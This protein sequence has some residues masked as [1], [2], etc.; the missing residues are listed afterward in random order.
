L[1]TPALPGRPND[2]TTLMSMR[3]IAELAGVKRPVVTTWRR[4]HPDFPGPCGGDELGPLF[5]PRQVADWLVRTGRITSEQA[6]VDLSFYTLTGLGAGLS[7]KDLIAGVTALICLR[8]LDDGEPLAGGTDDIAGDLIG[9][10]ERLDP[11][12]LLVRSEIRHLGSDSGQLAPA[13]DALIEAA[14]G[15]GDA[16]ERIMTARSQLRAA[17]L[18]ADSV[19]PGLARLIARISGARERARRPG[20]FTVTDLDAAVGDLLVA[21]AEAIGEDQVPKFIAA[22]SDPFLARLLRRRLIVHGVLRGD[23]DIRIADELPDEAG[24]PDIIVTQIPYAPAEERSADRVLDAIDDVSLRLGRG[25]CAVVLGPADVLTGE[26]NPYS[27]AERARSELLT[28]GIVEAIVRLPGGLVPFRPGYETAIWVLTAEQDTR[29]PGRILLADVSSHD[30]TTD[31]IEA[32]T[33]DI[34][35]WRRDGY[36]PSAHTRVFATQHRIS[37]FTDSPRPLIADRQHSIREFEAESA[38]RV[39]RV[40][41]LEAE[42][43]RIGATATAQ[44]RPVRSGIASGRRMPP[45]SETIGSL[46]RAGRLIVRQGIRLRPTDVIADGHHAVF[47]S[48]ETLGQARLGERTVDRA[49]LA[50]YRRAQLTDPGDVIVT[51]LPEFGVVVDHRGLAVVEYPARILRIPDSEQEQFSPRVL[52]ALLTAGGL[53]GRPPGAVRQAQR[54]EDFR[55]ALLS[56]AEVR[57][58]DVLLAHLDE[59]RRLV[60]QELDMLG[61]LRD[62]TTTGLVDGTLILTGD[63]T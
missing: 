15:E 52:A 8:Y 37:E 46:G 24:D 33:E 60:Q 32:L 62:I 56:P 21:V 55:V 19:T 43:D 6:G 5:Y 54:L 22:E 50:R 48:H 27:S 38:A 59:R 13:V 36:H 12:D 49:V 57:L 2:S 39:T 14:W 40:A 28:R 9:R 58:L 42:L 51:T 7:V 25:C 31:V 18:Y 30:L 44:R 45:P 61:E 23:M 34:T 1:T 11:Q 16:F 47:G 3:E 29:W 35:T 63:A 26:L 41:Q 17:D 4:R 10:A 53:G 20:S